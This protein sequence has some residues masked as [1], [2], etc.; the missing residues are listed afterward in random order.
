MVRPRCGYDAGWRHGHGQ[1]Q[2]VH[3]WLAQVTGAALPGS[4]RDALVDG[5]LLCRVLNAVRPGVVPASAVLAHPRTTWEKLGNTNLYLACVLLPAAGP[6]RQ[7]ARTR[8]C[9][10]LALHVCVRAGWRV[11]LCVHSCCGCCACCARQQRVSQDRDARV[12]AVL[13]QRAH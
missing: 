12:T 3:D 13:P 8:A 5:V 6:R 7:G 4:F 9:V 10:W 2:Q 1:V 11:T